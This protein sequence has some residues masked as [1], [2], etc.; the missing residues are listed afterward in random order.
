[1][2]QFFSYPI[3][4]SNEHI[5]SLNHVNNE[6]YIKW[7]MEAATAHSTELGY[8]MEKYL[9]DKACFVVRRHE[10]DYLAPAYF[11]EELVLETWILDMQA[12]K[13][14]RIYRIKRIQ[15]NKVLIEAKTLWVYISLESGKAIE[16]PAELRTA[17]KDFIHT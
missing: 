7:L 1:M 16:I 6:I 14:Y 11:G 15:D 12:T 9:A 13:T 10:V 5:D 2:K 17:F 3:K 8:P 4:V